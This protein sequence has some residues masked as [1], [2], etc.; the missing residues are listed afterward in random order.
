MSYE[1]KYKGAKLINV[2]DHLGQWW[3]FEVDC[4]RCG[5]CCLDRIG[6]NFPNKVEENWINEEGKCKWL[7]LEQDGNW[8]TKC[9]LYPDRPQSCAENDPHII[10]DYCQVVMRKVDDLSTLL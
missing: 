4:Q 10:P 3:E 9:S 8:P 2:K 6:Q 7:S 1:F 5:Q